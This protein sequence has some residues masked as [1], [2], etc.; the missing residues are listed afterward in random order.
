M[1][2]EDEMTAKELKNLELQQ[3]QIP[4]ML[5]KKKEEMSRT[6]TGLPLENLRIKNF[7]NCSELYQKC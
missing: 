4:D 6:E 5:T 3:Y 1:D 2:D 7:N